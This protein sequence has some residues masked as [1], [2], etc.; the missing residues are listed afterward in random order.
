M[1]PLCYFISQKKSV[2]WYMNWTLEGYFVYIFQHTKNNRNKVE[3]KQKIWQLK[4]SRNTMIKSKDKVCQIEPMH[5]IV[6]LNS[7]ETHLTF[8]QFFPLHVWIA[9]DNMAASIDQLKAKTNGMVSTLHLFLRH[10]LHFSWNGDQLQTT[11][12]DF[13]QLINEDNQLNNCEHCSI[14]PCHPDFA[15]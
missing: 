5:P 7:S 3:E 9:L 2:K 12:N 10:D 8:S 13:N 15:K 14:Y 6:C 11:F 4:D 1:L